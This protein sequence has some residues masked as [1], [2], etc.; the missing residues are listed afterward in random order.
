ME[1]Y[2]KWS[3]MLELFK[4]IIILVVII[5]PPY[6]LLSYCVLKAEYG[7]GKYIF[8]VGLFFYLF[9]LHVL[10]TSNTLTN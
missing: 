2:K 5:L 6:L 9:F 8:G 1:L 3:T 7:R 10:S 4:I